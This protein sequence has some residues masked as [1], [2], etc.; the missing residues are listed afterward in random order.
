MLKDSQP[1]SQYS[2]ENSIMSD[3][4]SIYLIVRKGKKEKVFDLTLL[5]D[6]YNL[7]GDGKV[8]HTIWQGC[9]KAG[10]VPEKNELA[11]LKAYFEFI[12]RK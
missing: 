12:N 1:S 7:E 8:F 11:F 2:F 6:L 3:S 5:Q 9:K 4:F 10:L